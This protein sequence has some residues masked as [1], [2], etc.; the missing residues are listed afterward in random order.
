[1]GRNLSLA[2]AVLALFG[3]LNAVRATSFS[4]KLLDFPVSAQ[5][6][7]VDLDIN[8]HGAI[9]FGDIGNNGTISGIL[10][11]DGTFVP[12]SADAVG[13]RFGSFALSI[14]DAGQVVGP[15]FLYSAGVYTAFPPPCTINLYPYFDCA[16]SATAINNAG[17]IVGWCE[18]SDSG[19]YPFLYD[20]GIVQLITLPTVD[21]TF[22]PFIK[23]ASAPTI[24]DAGQVAFS[25]YG[26]LIYHDGVLTQTG[27]PG[28]N[29]GGSLQINGAIND[30][31]WIAGNYGSNASAFLYA[32]GVTTVIN[33]PGAYST[34]ITGI[35]NAGQMVGTFQDSTSFN[36]HAFLATPV[37]EPDSSVLFAWG[38]VAIAI[39][40]RRSWCFFRKG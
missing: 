1:M 4:F 14:N 30:E 10:E 18:C 31:G 16:L 20:H 2:S 27:L 17:Q 38:A 33:Y 22:N 7:V 8:N 29:I 39:G 13:G 19:F 35:N 15:G 9:L 5:T 6:D 34:L 40:M 25:E 23:T 11:P 24:N 28:G 36:R 26:I 21:G 12:F 32:D 37:P 3:S